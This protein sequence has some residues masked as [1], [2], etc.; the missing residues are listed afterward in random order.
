MRP[1]ALGTEARAS[2]DGGDDAVTFI[3]VDVDGVLNV[4]IEDPGNQMLAFDTTNVAIALRYVKAG[5][6]RAAVDTTTAR[7]SGGRNREIVDKLVATYHREL[8]GEGE[9]ATFAALAADTFTG[10]SGVLISRLAELVRTSDKRPIVVLSSSWRTKKHAM[11][12]FV[13]EKLLSKY[14][15]EAFAFDARTAVRP[16]RSPADRLRSIGDFLAEYLAS[17]SDQGPRAARAPLPARVLVL[18]DFFGTSAARSCDWDCDGHHV[19]CAADAESY[20][21][22]R[23]ASAAANVRVVNTCEEWVTPDGLPV[24]IGAGLTAEHLGKARAFLLGG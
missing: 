21:L 20:I 6:K 4:G 2:P 18:D 13:L 23:M 1:S 17:V 7:S 14:L 15:G 12:V 11:K 16:E 22:G 19:G 3:F 24:R 10:V 9:G 8:Q 5:A